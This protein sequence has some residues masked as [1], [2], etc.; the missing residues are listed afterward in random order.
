V[1][2]APVADRSAPRPWTA[3]VRALAGMAPL[4]VALG[5][6]PA[7]AETIGGF[8]RQAGS[9]NILPFTID[10]A[11]SVAQALPAAT[12]GADRA[13]HFAAAARVDV[14]GSRLLVT[15]FRPAG[16]TASSLATVDLDTGTVQ[17][18]T[19]PLPAAAFPGHS[20]ITIPGA[21]PWA[22]LIAQDA[23]KIFHLDSTSYTD[24]NTRV[25]RVD[26]TTGTVTEQVTIPFTFTSSVQRSRAQLFI[27]RTRP[28]VAFA[29]QPCPLTVKQQ[30]VRI[31]LATT[32][33][34]VNLPIDVPAD[35]CLGAPG[36]NANRAFAL[37]TDGSLGAASQLVRI[38]TGT[39]G[40]FF[41]GTPPEGFRRFDA[42]PYAYSRATNRLYA[43]NDTQTSVATYNLLTG[44]VA[45][46]P[47]TVPAPCAP[48]GITS[49][50][51][52]P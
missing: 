42:S 32:P 24:L 47:F 9:A 36:A 40:V 30:L 45:V 29:L 15:G 31:N 43:L 28:T 14:P 27:D 10:S 44:A 26:V 49:L 39:G 52:L 34:T 20:M 23:G 41:L 16:A 37:G 22:V 25:F 1:S 11:T 50:A 46:A 5:V 51:V 17:L 3:K 2:A 21:T 38:N 18:S 35:Y 48:A 19:N 13:G 33:W 4:A 8:C 7:A 12:L 6:A